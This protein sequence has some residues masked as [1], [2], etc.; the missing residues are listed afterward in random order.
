MP[1]AIPLAGLAISAGMSA[2]QIS[3]SN[4]QKKE[5]QKAIE[6][7]DR[8]DLTNPAEGLQISTDGADR[9]RE[10][11]ARNISTYANA[12]MAGG[13]RGVNAFMPQALAMANQQNAEIAANLNEQ[14]MRRQAAIAQGQANLQNMIE[15]RE[16][17]DLLG[18]GNMMNVASQERMNAINNLAK[19]AVSAASLGSYLNTGNKTT[20]PT[21]N[22]NAEFKFTNP[23]ASNVNIQ[24]A[25][26][27]IFASQPTNT[28][29]DQL[30]G[31]QPESIQTFN[32]PN[33]NYGYGKTGNAMLSNNN[34]GLYGQ[35]L[36]YYNP[37]FPFR[38]INTN[39]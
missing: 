31:I 23:P 39:P 30:R 7:Y 2:Y 1:A 28:V 33:L 16:N 8:Q 35:E 4:K 25:A 6:G 13:S 15:T 24:P 11:L 19:T 5:E 17:N 27:G 9:Q 26:T 37:L 38:K 18:Y 12:A 14:E 34:F 21:S 22:V 29:A 32:A 20:P 10:D 36:N 3:Q